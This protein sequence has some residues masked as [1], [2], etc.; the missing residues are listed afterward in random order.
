MTCSGVEALQLPPGASLNPPRFITWT[1]AQSQSNTDVNFVIAT[2]PDSCG[3]RA[4]QSWT[5]HV[6]PDATPP[7]VTSTSPS[8]R[9]TPVL[10]NS[11]VTVE[12]SE[13]MDGSTITSMTLRL[14]DSF[15]N[16]VAA[17]VSSSGRNA[18]LDPIAALTP[19]TTYTTVVTT[20][21]RDISGNALATTYAWTFTT[22][23][24]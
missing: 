21:V 23:A 14:L 17:V 3:K 6:A 11:P 15:G 22:G 16:L 10:T 19:F 4:I 5:V 9:A 24:I 1:P 2:K 12:F 8:N 13:N 18:V 20:G 7:T